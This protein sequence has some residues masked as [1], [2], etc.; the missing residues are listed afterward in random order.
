MDMKN[1]G[2]FKKAMDAFDHYNLK[3]PNQEIVNGQRVS[4]ELAYAERMTNLLLQYNPESSEYLQL[5][6]RSQHIGRWEIARSSYP[7]DRKGYMQWRNK[8]KEHHIA[9]VE[10]I[11]KNS[12]YDEPTIEKVKFLL[13]KKELTSNPDMQTLEDVIC[14]VFLKY[15]VE[16]FVAK[17]TR[18]KVVDILHKTIKKMSAKAIE[19][20][21]EIPLSDNVKSMIHEAV[22]R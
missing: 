19:S 5:A 4:K 3:D 17:R 12:G 10:P 1:E 15:Y 14:L 9:I 16:E 21:A 7:M 6:A 18:E 2:N 11:L 13:L 22:S 20:A 8:L